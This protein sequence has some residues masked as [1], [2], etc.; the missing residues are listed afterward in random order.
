MGNVHPNEFL[1]G[2]TDGMVFRTTPIHRD[3]GALSA[4]KSGLAIW[5]VFWFIPMMSLIPMNLFPDRLLVSVIALG[6]VE[7]D[8]AALFGAWLYKKA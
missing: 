8:L 3:E 4:L 1:R 2:A 7:V 5:A 6:F